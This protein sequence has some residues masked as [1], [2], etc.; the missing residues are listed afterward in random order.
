[1]AYA[2]ASLVHHPN[3]AVTPA[4]TPEVQAAKAAHF[5]SKGAYG[6]AAGYA[7]PHGGVYAAAPVAHG[8]AYGAPAYGIH[9]PALQT[10]PNGA[11]TPPGTRCG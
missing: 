5:A 11:V 4:E 2:S 8:Y 3:G 9:V 7:I 1:M 6:Y 10:H